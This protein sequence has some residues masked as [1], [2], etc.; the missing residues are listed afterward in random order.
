[1]NLPSGGIEM[2]EL[3]IGYKVPML[4]GGEAEILGLFGSGGQ[5]SVYRTR[6]EGKEYALKWYLPGTIKVP[7]EFQK[8]LNLNINDGAPTSAFLWP[9][10]LTKQ[11][12]NSFGY[13]MDV[14][15]SNFV[16]F[17]CILNKKD[18]DGNKI[19]FD[20][21]HGLVNCALNIVNAFRFTR[22]GSSKNS[23]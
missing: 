19:E 23:G 10:F 6:F 5:G 17:S 8:N 11:I 22:S 13:I 2:R 9:K 18:K 3:P 15:P 14:R 20:D 12:D 1:V 7:E 21:L 4:A 16:E